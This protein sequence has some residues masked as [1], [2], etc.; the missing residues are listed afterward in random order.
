MITSLSVSFGPSPE[1]KLRAD[2]LNVVTTWALQKPSHKE[3]KFLAATEN[4]L[5]QVSLATSVRF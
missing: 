1:L 3:L 2:I 4:L 5:K